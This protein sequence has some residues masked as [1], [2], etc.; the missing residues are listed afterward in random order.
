VTVYGNKSY[1]V[2]ATLNEL[3]EKLDE[4][5][6]RAGRSFVINLRFVHRVTKTDV[7]LTDGATVPLPRGQYD[8]LNR[9]LI[10]YL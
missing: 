5:F 3:S 6:Y 4:T 8:L 1:T 2:K 9:A 7:Y 10:K